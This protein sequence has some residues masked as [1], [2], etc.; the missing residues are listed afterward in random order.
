V[1]ARVQQDVAGEPAGQQ[2]GEKQGVA[3]DRVRVEEVKHMHQGDLRVAEAG[4]V[5]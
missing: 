1:H 5:G 4:Q 2:G 3:V